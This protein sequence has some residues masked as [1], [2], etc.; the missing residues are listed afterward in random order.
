MIIAPWELGALGTGCDMYDL[1]I[2]DAEIYDGTGGD[3]VKGNLWIENGRVA[4][5]GADAPAARQ[6]IDAQGLAL[7]PGFVDLHTHFDAQVT[8]DRTCSPS[9][10]LGVT[11]CV[12]G[13]CGFGIVPS[14]PEVR[15]YIMNNLSVVEGMDLDALRAGIDWQFETFPE[16]MA[17]LERVGP[18]PNMAVFI[19]HSAVRTAVMRDEA[20]VREIPTDAELSE[21]RRLVEGALK[22]GA[23][24]FASSFSI[25][26]SGYGGIP[27]P[28]TIASVDEF[29]HLA[30][31]V[32]EAGKGIVQMSA[33]GRGNVAAM[34]PIVEKIGRRMFLTTGAAM[35][36]ASDPELG[37]SWFEDCAEARERGNELYIQIPC[38]PLSFDFTMANAYPFHSLA[39]FAD[40]KAA[41]R[42]ELIA[43]YKDPAFRDRFR[44]DLK[45]PVVGTI[46]KGTWDRV[47]IAAPARDENA[48]LQNRN[49]ADLA[50]EQS[51]D[52]MDVMFDLAL[53]EN[54]E[55]AFL[56]KFLN[57]GDEGVGRLLQHDCGVVSLSD[58]GAHLIYMCDAGYGL[59]LLSRWVRELG[60]FTLAEG[61][62]RLTSHPADLYGIKGRGRLTPGSH[63]DMVMFDPATIGVS[64]PQRVSDLPGGGPRTIRQPKGVHG[65]WING[66]QVF[67]GTDYVELAKGPG[68][69]LR[70]FAA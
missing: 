63:A 11:T 12:M 57:V 31:A 17:A 55:T 1:L 37:I 3:P 64:D 33:G 56:G 58:A 36:N 27:M 52:P 23:V 26:H 29:G 61:V 40:I 51:A 44:E 32:G 48:A 43:V 20:W 14:P 41:S 35:Y 54:L 2:K 47:V 15:D 6:E 5:V 4:G 10:S 68:Q 22:D 67:D 38:Q 45:K 7:M 34:E 62:R 21:M 13:N 59:H 49:I 42:E 66:T 28:S 65:V 18:Y 24:G 60:V 19:G 8:W 53:S 9:P 16:Y 25:N 39:S 46:F 30:E 50:A 70:D 69:V